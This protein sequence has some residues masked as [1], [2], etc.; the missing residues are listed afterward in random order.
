MIY[1]E[2]QKDILLEYIKKYMNDNKDNYITKYSDYKIDDI[3]DIIL[4][5]LYEQIVLFNPTKI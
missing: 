1:M 5:N 2:V 4:Y 3:L